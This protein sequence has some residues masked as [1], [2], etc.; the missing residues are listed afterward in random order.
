MFEDRTSEEFFETKYQRA[1]DPWDFAT[2][3]YEQDRYSAILRALPRQRFRRAF[4]PGCSIGT[5]TEKLAVFCGKVEAM[6]ISATAAARTRARCRSFRNVTVTHG[7]LPGAVPDGAFD[8]IVLSEVGYY[9]HRAALTTLLTELVGRLTQDGVLLA[10]HWLGCST[11][12]Q[13]SGD[14]IHELIGTIPGLAHTAAQRH[15]GFR[16]DIW[17]PA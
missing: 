9:F 11:D 7:A 6:D 3:A 8:L 1:A 13:L 17:T 4:E 2:S 14:Q 16:I 12:H 5:L 15:E 10:A